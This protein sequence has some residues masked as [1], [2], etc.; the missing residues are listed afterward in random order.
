M[1]FYEKYVSECRK[2]GL[3]PSAAAQKMGLSKTAVSHW[4]QRGSVPTDAVLL[5]LAEYFG[6]DVAEFQ[7]AKIETLSFK[8]KGQKSLGTIGMG[9]RSEKVPLVGTIAC[10]TPILAYENVEEMIPVPPQG[11]SD[12]ALKCRGESMKNAGIHDGDIVYIRLQ[13]E[14]INGRIYAVLIGDDATLK[15]VYV[16]EDRVVLLPENDDY[17]PLTYFGEEMAEISILG[18]AVG[19][20]SRLNKK[21]PEQEG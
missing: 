5:T 1:T 19:V 16:Y 10:G 9:A 8:M 7:A 3:T 12:F 15:K 14:V 17:S 6:C 21:K 18:E 2:K 20:Y 11:H 13:P 4:K